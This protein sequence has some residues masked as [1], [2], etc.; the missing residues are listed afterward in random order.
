LMGAAPYIRAGESIQVFG[1]EWSVLSASDWR[2]DNTASVPV[3]QL[4]TPKGPVP[5][6]PRRPQQFAIAQTSDFVKVTVDAEVMPRGRS[7]I[8]VYNYR[9]PAHFDYAH[10][11]TD[12][13]IKQPVHNGVFHVFGG[14]RVRISAQNGPAAF[15]DKDRW[16]RVNLVQDGE[17]GSVLVEVDGKPIPALHAVDLSLN[18]GKVGLGSF[19]E[20]GDFK[21]VRISGTAARGGGTN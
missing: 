15:A 11:S 20:I 17:T 18:S 14:E 2:I 3:L 21:D 4:L 12:T 19:D 8:I 13:A 9:D 7:L 10:L 6:Q 16:Y 5:G 1:H